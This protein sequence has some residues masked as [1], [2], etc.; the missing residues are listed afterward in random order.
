MSRKFKRYIGFL[1][2][3][4]AFAA[5]AAEAT[6]L[7]GAWYENWM[8]PEKVTVFCY[9]RRRSTVRFVC[10]D[11]LIQVL[12]AN[13]MLSDTTLWLEWLTYWLTDWLI[14]C[15]SSSNFSCLN[16]S[17]LFTCCLLLYRK[18]SCVH[19]HRSK[20]S[21]HCSCSCS[22]SCLT[23]RRMHANCLPDGI[24]TGRK[25]RASVVLS[26]LAAYTGQISSRNVRDSSPVLWV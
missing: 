2:N 16:L 26:P 23:V 13:Q 5:A 22:S 18:L 8:W 9:C 25:S 4:F 12:E 14:R 7:E 21:P 6:S 11:R 10:A 19:C 24:L 1:N 17:S 3:L 20:S 15:K